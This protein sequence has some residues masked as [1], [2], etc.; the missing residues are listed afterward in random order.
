MKS[1]TGKYPNMVF[2]TLYE[3]RAV[4]KF[5]NTPIDREVILQLLDAGRMAP[6]AMNRQ[7]WQFYVLTDPKKIQAYSQAIMGQAKFA[8]L[9]SGA[10]EA[11]HHIF[12][13][14][15]FHFRD[16]IEFFKADDPIFHAAPAVI[17]I[18]SDKNSEW[19]PLDIGMCSQNIMLAAQS[20][21]LATCPVGFAKFIENTREYKELRVPDSERIHLAIL[22]GYA[23]ESPAV[24]ERKRDNAV[25]IGA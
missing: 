13:P 22:V 17:F 9:R 2:Q 3:R 1:A 21:G 15:S 11:V 12:H 25:F 16:G 24:H 10:K 18:A 14:A 20:L 6:S 8:M 23:D 19:A 7:P 4:R 5:K